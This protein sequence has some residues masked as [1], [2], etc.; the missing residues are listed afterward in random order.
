MVRTFINE[1]KNDRVCLLWKIELVILTNKNGLFLEITSSRR[2]E[3]NNRL[4]FSAT[5]IDDNGLLLIL[6]NTLIH[7][8]FQF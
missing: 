7:I 5:G 8:F 6:A 4:L 3:E 1:A 2:Q